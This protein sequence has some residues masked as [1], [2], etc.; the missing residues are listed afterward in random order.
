[1]RRLMLLMSEAHL[2]FVTALT[3]AGK[4]EPRQGKG[5][6]RGGRGDH[7]G[8]VSCQ[9]RVETNFLM[10]CARGGDQRIDDLIG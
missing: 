10:P 6:A 4:G 5:L 7:R 3:G 2:I 9:Y 8:F 1:M